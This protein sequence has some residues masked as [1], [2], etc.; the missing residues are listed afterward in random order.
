[1]NV[2]QEIFSDYYEEIK[3]TLHPRKAEMENIDKMIHCGDPSFGGAMY[4]CPHCEHLKFVPFRCHSRFCPTCGNKYSMERT[5][6]MSFKLVNVTHRHC[7][8]T[9]DENLRHFFLEDRSLLDCLFHAVWSYVKKKYKLNVPNFHVPAGQV[10]LQ[11]PQQI[12]PLLSDIL[13]RTD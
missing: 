5:T 4:F 2:L 9:I 1:M 7:V 6:S 12:L 8:F 3:Y 13:L 11:E 10:S